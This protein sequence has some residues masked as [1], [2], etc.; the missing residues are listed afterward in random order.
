VLVDVL[1]DACSKS[2]ACAK[3]DSVLDSVLDSDDDT[4]NLLDS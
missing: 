3:S 1:D 4:L 2:D